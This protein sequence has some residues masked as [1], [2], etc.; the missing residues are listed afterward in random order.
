MS[1]TMTESLSSF[2]QVIHFGHPS[3]VG[4]EVEN[5]GE[6]QFKPIWVRRAGPRAWIYFDPPSVRAAIVTCGGLCPGLNDVVRQI[7]LS[8]EVYGVKEILGLQYGFK[9]FVDKRYPPIMLTRKIVQRIHMVGGSFL[10][11]SRG[12]PPLEDI[13]SKLEE[14]KVNMFFVIGGNGSHAGANAIYQHVEKRKLKLVVVGIPKTIDN[15]IQILD[16]TFGFDT[17]VEEAQRAINAAYVEASSAFN[18]VG[19]VKLMG[20]QSGYITMYATIASGQVDAVLIPEVPFELEGEYGVLEFMHQRLK[21][22]GIAV[23]VIA[24]GAGQDMMEGVGGTDASGNPILGDIGKYFFDKVKAFFGTLKFPVDV[25]YIDPTYM[26]RARPCNSSDHIFCSILGQNAVHGAFAGYTNIT[27]GVVNT[28]YCFLPIPEVIRKPRMVDP[29]SNMYQRCVTSTGQ[30]EF[31][32]PNCDKKSS[33]VGGGWKAGEGKGT[34]A[35]PHPPPDRKKNLT[36]RLEAT[37]GSD[38]SGHS[39]TCGAKPPPTTCGQH[40]PQCGN[41]AARSNYTSSGSPSWGGSSN[42]SGGHEPGCPMNKPKSESSCH[43]PH[44]PIQRH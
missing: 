34:G 6:W 32:E 9:G 26:I 2:L 21:K 17:A 20:R 41:Q 29:R 42:Q 5:D 43:D 19:I 30:P 1:T 4:I 24:E 18:G 39:P 3:S 31:Q 28:H 37:R 38:G 22:N 36:L 16:K 33:G 44:C 11:V 13:C 23:V 8:L 14:W 15:D 12:C 40:S 27:V 7:V 10:G 25:K 35:P